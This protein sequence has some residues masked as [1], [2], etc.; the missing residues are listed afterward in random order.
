MRYRVKILLLAVSFCNA[1]VVAMQ[2][3]TSRQVRSVNVQQLLKTAPQLAEDAEIFLT[4]SG[5]KFQVLL[6]V[7]FTPCDV[8]NHPQYTDVAGARVISL[9]RS[10]TFCGL[11]VYREYRKEKLE[12]LHNGSSRLAAPVIKHDF[13]LLKRMLSVKSFVNAW[14]D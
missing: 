5:R 1:H 8:R 3:H 2:N 7:K 11:C 10:V 4:D 12:F 6:D 14:R 13:D 9:S